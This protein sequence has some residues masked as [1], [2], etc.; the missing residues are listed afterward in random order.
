MIVE[1][2]KLTYLFSKFLVELE[3]MSPDIYSANL[4]IMHNNLCAYSDK[5]KTKFLEFSKTYIVVKLEN[6][7]SISLVYD[8]VDDCIKNI[9]FFYTVINIIQ[10]IINE[11]KCSNVDSIVNLINCFSNNMKDLRAIIAKSFENYK[12]LDGSKAYDEFIFSVYCD[13]YNMC[14]P[15]LKYNHPQ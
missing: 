11:L 10:N 5:L 1:N 8:N 7:A 12:I 4:N 14:I 2:T 3:K 6:A 13:L 15:N 9:P